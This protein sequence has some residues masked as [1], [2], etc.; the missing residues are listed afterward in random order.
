[1]S[2]VQEMLSML[3]RR[4]EIETN[5]D[6]V[7]VIDATRSMEPMIEKVKEATLT[8]H[9]EL[10]SALKEYRRAINN[11]RVK[12]VWFRDFYFDGKY[13]YGE[14]RFFNLPAERQPFHDYVA[15]IEAKGGFD[16]P[17]SALEALTLAMRSDFVTEGERK[18]HVI[19]LFTDEEAHPFEDYDRL[20]KEAAKYGIKPEMYPPNMFKNIKEFYNAWD[21]NSSYQEALGKEGNNTKLDIYG[22]RL[23]L[24]TP[25]VYPWSEMEIDLE[26]VL[27][28]ELEKGGSGEDLN[29]SDVYPMI[30]MSMTRS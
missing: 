1:M 5:V 30:A 17:E 2:E 26:N 6:I 7:F 11:L 23:V 24:C 28:I 16:E 9:E 13:A 10:Y 4:D 27:H 21:G 20:C 25:S 12:V 8:F 3:G 19:V 14:S 15:G 18:R 22:R 29:M